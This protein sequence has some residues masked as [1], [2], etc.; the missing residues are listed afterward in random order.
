VLPD[1]WPLGLG[2]GGG[3]LGGGLVLGDGDPAF[4]GDELTVAGGFG[5]TAGGE[6]Q[7]GDGG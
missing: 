6:E 7:A 1:L 4:T 3:G 2:S 5:G